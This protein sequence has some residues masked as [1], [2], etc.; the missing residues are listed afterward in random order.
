[1]NQS[2]LD[3]SS[4]STIRNHIIQI[5]NKDSPVRTLLCNIFNIV[6]IFHKSFNIYYLILANRFLNYLRLVL[7]SKTIPPPPPGF[8]DFPDE[9]DSI[10]TAFKRLTTYN[11]AVYS[12]FYHEML[13]PITTATENNP[14]QSATN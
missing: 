14:S 4:E 13:T 7:R 3:E 2:S 1:M 5:A 10:A 6:L 8:T 9:A 11:Y 12:E